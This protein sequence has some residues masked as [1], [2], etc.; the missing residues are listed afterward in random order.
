M[1]RSLIHLNGNLLC[2][3]DVET[4][5]LD[6]EKHDIWH[7]CILPLDSNIKPIKELFPFYTLLKPARPENA[8]PKAINKNTLAHSLLRGLDSDRAADMLYE[9]FK[10]IGLALD[11]KLCP[12]A[13]NWPFDNRFLYKWLGFQQFE[14]IFHPWYRDLLPTSL[15]LN[16]CA[17]LNAEPVP[18]A[19]SNLSYLCAK[20]EVT[21]E[22]PHDPLS[23]CVAT[24]ECY[25]RIMKRLF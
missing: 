6:S 25:R 10:K 5:G 14:E 20:L 9:W 11:K 16:D 17:D 15:Y 12:L 2:A 4:T 1:A 13:Q 24:A 23:D 7:L 18:Y 19:K 8:D 21:N 22:T 3:V